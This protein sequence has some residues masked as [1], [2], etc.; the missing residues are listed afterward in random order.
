MAVD[1][2]VCVNVTF[3]DMLALSNREGLGFDELSRRLGCG[4]NCGLCAPYI[5]AALATGRCEF[6]VGPPPDSNSL[7]PPDETDL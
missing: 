1:R 3:R 6:P 4:R 2:C 5:R 7:P